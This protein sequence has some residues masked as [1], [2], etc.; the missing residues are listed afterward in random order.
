[1]NTLAPFKPH[2]DDD[3]YP[4]GRIERLKFASDACDRR[5][6]L[7]V[8]L[9]PSYDLEPTRHYPVLYMHF[10]NELFEPERF[11]AESWNLHR[12][13][14][15]L[16]AAGL[17]EEIIV[18][19]IDTMDRTVV[20]DLH[21]YH[22]LQD[23]APGTGLGG[24]EY[25]AF[26][27]EHLMPF[28]DGRFRT[29]VG[30]EHTAMMGACAGATVTYNIAE[31]N[32]GAFGKIGLLSPAILSLTGREWL[33]AAPG[34]RPQGLV[35]IDAGALEG[36]F[37]APIRPLVD[38]LID[39][40]AKPGVDLFYL[41][42]PDAPHRAAAWAE[43]VAHPLL[44]FFG[45]IG[46]PVRAQLH[47][48]DALAVD[49]S[50]IT[51]NPV[52]E[53][54]TGFRV[55]P[56]VAEYRVSDASLLRAVPDGRLYGLA[57]GSA[58]IVFHAA[59]CEA[60]HTVR[61][62]KDLPETVCLTLRAKVLEDQPTIKLI[63]FSLLVLRRT[64]SGFYEGTFRLRRGY[65]LGENFSCRIGQFELCRDSSPVP[66]RVLRAEQ[67]AELEFTIDRWPDINPQ[68]VASP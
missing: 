48:E 35:W 29:R 32:P 18:V 36:D 59:G 38:A 56:L 66:L 68:A 19:G 60:R 49:G 46:Q 24:L 15:R 30:P 16:L 41:L 62:V 26:I 11:G 51:L 7:H 6:N 43:R 2:G 27:L 47:G 33:L 44:L 17:I 65:A 25:E 12:L 55:T 37:S 9:P 34:R 67:D 52:L 45:R 63:N 61:V 20:Q 57:E 50:P 1:M 64:D 10:G 8:Y 42:E 3:A 28:I 40:G 31:R 58:E 14:D 54:D 4:Q 22:N 39:W 23:D 21:H 13:I 53:Y 5:Q